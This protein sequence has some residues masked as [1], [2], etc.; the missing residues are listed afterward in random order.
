VAFKA[1]EGGI[2]AEVLNSG[3]QPAAVVL[4]WR[5]KFLNVGL[6]ALSITTCLWNK[7]DSL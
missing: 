5:G 6:P 1:K 4:Q 3:K 2:V 7:S